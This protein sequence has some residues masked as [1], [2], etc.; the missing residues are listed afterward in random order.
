MKYSQKINF[1]LILLLTFNL[2]VHASVIPFEYYQHLIFLK[3]KVNSNDSLLFLFDTGANTSAID[4]KTADVLNLKIIRIDNVEGTAGIIDVPVVNAKSISVG[5]SSVKNLL[6]TKYD[7]STS[8]VPPNQHLDGI[9][10]T[11]FL[12]HFVV[13]IDFQN[14][15]ISL[16]KKVTNTL[17]VSF[18]FELDNGIP[19]VKAIINGKI[20]AFFRYDSGSSLFDTKDIYVN[21]TTPIFGMIEKADSTLN[22]VQYLSAAGLG[23]NMQLPVYKI[24]SLLLNTIKIKEP[25]LIIQPMQ[26]YFARQDAVGFVGNNLFEKFKIVT[27]DFIEKK[28]HILKM[29]L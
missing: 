15:E 2:N 18:P 4:Q 6:L 22:P 21:T 13:T 19:M 25:F 23:G 29:D 24:D 5:N 17:Q 26:G 3:L 14:K 8:L 9:L 20:P 10:G 27:I 1:S 16:S 12:K 28:I 7:L 11:D